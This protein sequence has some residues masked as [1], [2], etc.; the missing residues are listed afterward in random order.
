[1]GRV[2]QNE[3]GGGRDESRGFRQGAAKSGKEDDEGE[4]GEPDLQNGAKERR[5]SRRGVSTP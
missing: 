5:K 1:M 2:W 3:A 4:G